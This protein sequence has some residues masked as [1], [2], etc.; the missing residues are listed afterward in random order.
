MNIFPPTGYDPRYM[1]QDGAD[2]KWTCWFAWY[3]VRAWGIRGPE[4]ST[5]WTWLQ[6]VECR[7]SPDGPPPNDV[8]RMQFRIPR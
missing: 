4:L 1:P 6:F 7:L 8:S 3:P 5:R 2:A